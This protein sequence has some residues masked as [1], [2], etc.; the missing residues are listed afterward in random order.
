M[1]DDG[2]MLAAALK[3]NPAPNCTVIE[4]AP[5]R[6]P[7]AENSYRASSRQVCATDGEAG[8]AALGANGFDLLITDHDMRGL[9]GLDLLRRVRA[10][11]LD[12][13]AILISGNMPW[14][15]T[16]L[17]ELLPPGAALEKPFSMATLLAK[18]RVI[19]N[20]A[21][22]AN[23]DRDREAIPEL[24]GPTAPQPPPVA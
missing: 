16:D 20:P 5:P 17:L 24:Y 13:P 12:L 22:S 1:F 19:L 9:S 21:A 2:Q 23:E 7:V 6:K 10:R 18:V 3:P 15:E 14:D 8:C 4:R 11:L